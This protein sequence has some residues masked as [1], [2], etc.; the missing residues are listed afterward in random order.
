M[1]RAIV[2]YIPDRYLPLAALAAGRPD[3]A[4]V[5]LVGHGESTAAGVA[6]LLDEV[7]IY[8]TTWP[9]S[10]SSSLR[11]WTRSPVSGPMPR[12]RDAGR[13]SAPARRRRRPGGRPPATD[14]EA[15]SGGRTGR[16]VPPV[17]PR[18]P[19]ARRRW[20]GR[21]DRTRR[22][23][24]Q[25]RDAGHRGPIVTDVADTR[26]HVERWDPD[27]PLAVDDHRLVAGLRSR[28][29]TPPMSGWWPIET[30]RA[31]V[32]R[33]ASTIEL[34]R[35]G[36]DD[37]EQLAQAFAAVPLARWGG[38]ALDLTPTPPGVSLLDRRGT[39][40]SDG[41]SPMTTGRLRPSSHPPRGPPTASSWP[42]GPDR[43][44]PSVVTTTSST[45]SSPRRRAPISTICSTTPCWARS[46]GSC[47]TRPAWS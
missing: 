17:A 24:G 16:G 4:S 6:E 1:R 39:A 33:A 23:R 40:S 25:L 46:L 7:S 11:R 21:G 9:D 32:A 2:E 45:W 30:S 18:R 42:C 38:V 27:G 47:A 3:A 20:C 31:N 34:D 29:W 37:L 36:P 19:V 22:V 8:E 28:R 43:P 44:V 15:T 10:G 26:C 14:H 35:R 12:R 5:H 13:Q 41:S